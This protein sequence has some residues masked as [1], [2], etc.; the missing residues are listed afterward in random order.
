MGSAMFVD[1]LE[2]DCPNPGQA[3]RAKIRNNDR[4]KSQWGGSGILI[5]VSLKATINILGLMCLFEISTCPKI[6]IAFNQKRKGVRQLSE[7]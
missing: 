5:P 7:D 4:I 1:A 2:S 6:R 3:S